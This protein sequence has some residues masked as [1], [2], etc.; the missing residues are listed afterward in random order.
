[1]PAL[2]PGGWVRLGP[3]G[4]IGAGLPN[5]LALQWA[6]PGRPV[7]LITGDGSLGFY[8]IELDT[9][10]R[11]GLPVVII[12]GNDGCWGLERDLQLATTGVER[13]VACDLRQTRYDLVMRGFGGEGETVGSLDQVRPAV[14][15]AF[16]SGRPYLLNVL[17]RGLRSPF[18][19]W[20]LAGK[21][22]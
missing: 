21:R 8:I 3:L 2:V 18:V 6:N 5:A 12:A 17:I 11:H 16:A 13:T 1:M 15:R 4:T 7:A 20:Q 22:A 14:E 9:A 19:E 10:V